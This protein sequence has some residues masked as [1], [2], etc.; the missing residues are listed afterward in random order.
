[1]AIL[2]VGHVLGWGS[3]EAALTHIGEGWVAEEAV[4]LALYC[5]LRYPDD[6]VAIVRRGANSSGDSDSIAC[7]A[8]GISGALLGLDAIQTDWR[9]LCE[10]HDYLIDVADRLAAKRTH[11]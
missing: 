5:V 10:N 1:M 2:H 4:A 6:Y 11:L 9:Q 3:E 7:I 8:G